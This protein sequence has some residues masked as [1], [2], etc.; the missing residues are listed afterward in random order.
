[1]ASSSLE[2]QA[3]FRLNSRVDSDRILVAG[4]DRHPPKKY[5]DYTTHRTDGGRIKIS[6]GNMLQQY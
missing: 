6:E 1:V 4:F 3:K 5:N 2:E